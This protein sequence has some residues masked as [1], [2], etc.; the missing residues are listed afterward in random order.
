MPYFN[1]IRLYDA[2]LANWFRDPVFGMKVNGQLVPSVEGTSERAFSQIIDLLGLE[3]TPEQ[4]RSD[5]SLIPLPFMSY[6]HL[7]MQHDMSRHQTNR[8][9]KI[10]TLRGRTDWIQARYPVPY[11]ILYQVDIWCRYDNDANAILQQM[12]L[13]V[14]PIFYFDIDF[15]EPFGRQIIGLHYFS[16]P[17]NTSELDPAGEQRWVRYT[18]TYRMEAWMLEAFGFTSD[19]P[20]YILSPESF[21]VTRRSVKKI[22]L[23]I[24]DIDTNQIYGN[25]QIQ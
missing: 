2:A 15:R 3:L 5:S 24:L 4:L 14:D 20:P 8:F 1:I 23:Q 22:F 9:R 6:N 13:R 10:K 19:I 18:M 16:G 12:M 11:N 21:T 25:V 17:N 7:D